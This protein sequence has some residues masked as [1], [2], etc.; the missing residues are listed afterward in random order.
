MSTDH[1]FPEQELHKQHFAC[2]GCRKAFKQR[3]SEE[4]GV[5]AERPFPCPECGAPMLLVGRDFRA[6]P[7]R[8]VKQ[9]QVV[10]LLRNFGVVF[11]PGLTQPTRQPESLHEAE[12]FLVKQGYDEQV[13]RQRLEK[14][15]VARQTTK[16]LTRM[17]K[18]QR[19]C[20]GPRK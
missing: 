15:R 14:L 4:I 1:P 8:A 7:Q 11:E 10:E 20:R 6:P 2:F 9:W 19:E 5:E 3:G 16:P 18:K 12:A 13:I 17:Q